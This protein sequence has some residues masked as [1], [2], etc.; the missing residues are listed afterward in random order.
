MPLPMPLFYM[1]AVKTMHFYI[2][3]SLYVPPCAYSDY[4]PLI[5]VDREIDFVLS[6]HSVMSDSFVTPWTVTHPPPQAPP[7]MEFSRQH[8]WSGLPF[9][10][11][12]DLPNPGIESSSPAWQ[13]NSLSLSHL[14]SSEIDTYYY[15][16][17]HGTL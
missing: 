5:L 13:V 8:Y 1:N 11:S 10:S 17:G 15:K 2:S 4:A 16:L 9:P 7:A 14:R 6:S 3:L 12:R